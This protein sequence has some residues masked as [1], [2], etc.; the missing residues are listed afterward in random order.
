MPGPGPRSG[1]SS[2]LQLTHEA[3]V[4]FFNGNLYKTKTGTMLQLTAQTRRRLR[5]ILTYRKLPQSGTI[6]EVL[7]LCF[8]A[9]KTHSVVK[10]SIHINIQIYLHV[11]V[12]TYLNICM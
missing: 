5:A 10:T 2:K 9:S 12:F 6:T 7:K 3:Q 4:D 1:P 11:S 8:T